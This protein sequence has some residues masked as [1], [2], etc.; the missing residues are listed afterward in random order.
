MDMN[1]QPFMDCPKCGSR[2]I[3]FFDE[4]DDWDEDEDEDEIDEE[5]EYD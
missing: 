2:C 3:S 4:Y 5:D 1:N